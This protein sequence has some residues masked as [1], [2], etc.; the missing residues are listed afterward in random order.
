MAWV[1]HVQGAIAISSVQGE[2]TAAEKLFHRQLKYVT[3]S[4]EDL[5]SSYHWQVMMTMSLA[6]RRCWK[7]ESTLSI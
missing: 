2:E 6:V 3:V 5:T 1:A 4:L 7:A